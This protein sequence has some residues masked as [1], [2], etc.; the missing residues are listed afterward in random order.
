MD[1]INILVGINLLATLG[2]NLGGAKKGIINTPAVVVDRPR[3]YLQSIPPNVAVVILVFI[4]LSI[5]QVGT[6]DY[7]KFTSHNSL[8]IF[9]LFLYVAFS[10]FQIWAYKALGDNYSQD[11][12]IKKNQILITSGP[13]KYIRHP[14]YLGQ[15]LADLG[16][17]MALLSYIV[18]P[19]VLFLEIPLIV[20]RAIEEERLLAKHF[21]E[22]FDNYRKKTGFLLPFIG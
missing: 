8:R 13:F 3:T 4:I 2:A 18:M 9:G 11:I 19:L 12:Q 14:Q 20:L 15:I 5:F 21:R 7:K 10:W 22:K 17:S 16:A 6:L 1:P